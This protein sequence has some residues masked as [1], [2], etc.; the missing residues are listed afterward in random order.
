MRWG[1]SA[2]LGILN[3]MGWTVLSQ[4]QDPTP[5]FDGPYS[6]VQPWMEKG[7]SEF[8]IEALGGP[9]GSQSNVAE[10]LRVFEELRH[11][12]DPGD[13]DRYGAAQRAMRDDLYCWDLVDFLLWISRDAGSF[14]R[15]ERLGGFFERV[16]S[17]WGVEQRPD[18]TGFMLARRETIDTSAVRAVVRTHSEQVADLLDQARADIYGRKQDAKAAYQHVTEALELALA[19][20]VSPEDGQ[21]SLGKMLTAILDKPEKWS[22]RLQWTFADGSPPPEA[23]QADA[24]VPLVRA[25]QKTQA[26]HAGQS[27]IGLEEA[28]DAYI[29][30]VSHCALFLNGSVQRA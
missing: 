29:A 30:A 28:E 11:E 5:G 22:F 16:G 6:G 21:P 24:L 27:P 19:P 20:V 8:I 9:T 2:S 4:R 17:I 7:L 18:G 3:A 10:T 26:R 13:G 1:S 12:T 25:V 23:H 15:G 14:R